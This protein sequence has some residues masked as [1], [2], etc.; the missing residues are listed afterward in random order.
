MFTDFF[1]VSNQFGNSQHC[2]NTQVY[3]IDL[4][5][6]FTV[7]LFRVPLNSAQLS[8]WLHNTIELMISS[9]CDG[10]FSFLYYT[11]NPILRIPYVVWNYFLAFISL[12]T[13]YAFVIYRHS[14]WL[15]SFTPLEIAILT[16]I[17]YCL[18]CYLLLA[19]FRQYFFQKDH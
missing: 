13:G 6:T 16:C 18:T 11:Y 17:S 15:I 9:N 4:S 8:S 19:I 2:T 7:L 14:I 10:R 1:H 5:L 12:G 3:V